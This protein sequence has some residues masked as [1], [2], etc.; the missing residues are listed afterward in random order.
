M[1]IKIDSNKKMTN[2]MRH[3]FSNLMGVL[4]QFQQLHSQCCGELC[5]QFALTSSLRKIRNEISSIRK[6]CIK[7]LENIGLQS[8]ASFLFL[9]DN[10]Y[11]SQDRVDVK[12]IAVILNHLQMRPEVA[13][14]DDVASN[15]KCRL[16]S[17]DALGIPITGDESESV[18]FPDL[19]SLLNYVVNF[20]DIEFGPL[21]GEGQAGKVYKG[22]IK[23]TNQI[24]AIKILHRRTLSSF[25]LEMYRREIFSMSVLRHQNLVKFFGY[26]TEPPFCVLTE[27]MEFGSLYDFLLEHPNMHHSILTSVVT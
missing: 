8:T 21:I 16:N 22:K 10:E 25:D 15:L 24:V 18:A 20:E 9:D 7:C 26:T 5:A 19:P 2:A 23:T 13:K 27:Y 12:R 1:T 4:L 14:R 6:D 3:N 11:D 17:L